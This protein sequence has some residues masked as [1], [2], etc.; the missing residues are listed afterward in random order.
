MKHHLIFKACLIALPV[1]LAQG[2]GGGSGSPPPADFTPVG[3]GLTAIAICIV[4]YAVVQVLGSLAGG[5]KP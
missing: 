1:A 4:C 5:G 2:G 3:D